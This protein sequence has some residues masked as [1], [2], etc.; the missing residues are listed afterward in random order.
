MEPIPS[1]P[2]G[3]INA[4]PVIPDIVGLMSP[5]IPNTDFDPTNWYAFSAFCYFS[6]FIPTRYAGEKHDGIRGVYNAKLRK[7]FSRSGNELSIL[8]LLLND[9]PSMLVEGEITYVINFHYQV[10]YSVSALAMETT[11]KQLRSVITL[12]MIK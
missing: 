6:L 1:E 11:T 9:I 7:M 10:V 12:T 2:P 3:S 4:A 5:F 8:P